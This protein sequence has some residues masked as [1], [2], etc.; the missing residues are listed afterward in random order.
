MGRMVERVRGEREGLGRL[1]E[2]GSAVAVSR[3]EVATNL[4]VVIRKLRYQYYQTINKSEIYRWSMI[5]MMG[6]RWGRRP[7]QFLDQ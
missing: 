5:I 7:P 2:A 1:G 4:R 3:R 6:G